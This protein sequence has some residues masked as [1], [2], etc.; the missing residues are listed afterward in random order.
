MICLL[1]GL[2]VLRL[3]CL[4][5]RL[6]VLNCDLGSVGVCTLFVVFEFGLGVNWFVALVLGCLHF[7]LGV[8]VLFDC[9]NCL[10]AVVV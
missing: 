8:F 6:L 2:V 4:G 3:V 1:A 5:L 10:L 7:D 9:V